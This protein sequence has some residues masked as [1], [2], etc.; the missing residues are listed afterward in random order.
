MT[1]LYYIW[2]WLSIGVTAQSIRKRE[3]SREKF[4]N[5]RAKYK[6]YERYS[7][8]VLLWFDFHLVF[9]RLSVEIDGFK[10]KMKTFIIPTVGKLAFVQSKSDY[11]KPGDHWILPYCWRE[12][13]QRLSERRSVIS[14]A[15][16]EQTHFLFSLNEQISTL[17]IERERKKLHIRPVDW[18]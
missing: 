13:S 6:S 12:D 14:L 1:S 18:H 3:I 8:F 4:N 16:A 2:K 15:L 9:S 10:K 17:L 5:T 11:C 7:H